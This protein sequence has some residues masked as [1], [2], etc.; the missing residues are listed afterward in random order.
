MLVLFGHCVFEM[1]LISLSQ[2][3]TVGQMLAVVGER[4]RFASSPVRTQRSVCEADAEPSE[5]IL[6][7]AKRCV[8]DLVRRTNR[9]VFEKAS[10]G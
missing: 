9:T 7:V 4:N 8:D 6:L 5:V 3:Q 1:V 10:L 2:N